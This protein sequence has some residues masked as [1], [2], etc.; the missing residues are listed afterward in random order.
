M[1][2]RSSL[3][4][5]AGKL[6]GV[7]K[8]RDLSLRGATQSTRFIPGVFTASGGNK[9]DALAPGN[10]YKYHTFST[11]GNFVVTG[12]AGDIECL[13]VGGGGA[14][15]FCSGGGGGGGIAYIA[16]IPVPTGTYAVTVGSG[17]TNSNNSPRAPQ[18]NGGDS[19]IVLPVG[20]VTGYGG[21]STGDY[22][23][24]NSYPMPSTGGDGGSGAGGGAVAP[25]YAPDAPYPA[26]WYNPS[27]ATQPGKPTFGGVVTNYGVAGGRGGPNSGSPPDP[28]HLSGGGGGGAG[29]QGQD[30]GPNGPTYAGNGGVGQPFPS[31]AY[32]LCFPGSDTPNLTPHSPDNTHY[33]GG[34]G[35][36]LHRAGGGGTGAP[37]TAG[38]TGGYGGGGQGDNGPSNPG[39]C[40]GQDMLGGGSAGAGG[41]TST[42]SI[43]GGDGVV[44]IRYQV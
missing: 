31:F 20:T 14:A 8:E 44:I 36:G 42:S 34:G 23:P 29:G 37:N 12:A 4:R 18:P 26:P 32:P 43:T 6:L 39:T 9:S 15:D 40:N 3:A 24:G 19:S 38:G 5:S 25:Q 27:G 35:G 17:A 22:N 16:T 10:G 13:I 7:F 41:K 28:R 21:G 1:P 33:G 30:A 11:N 2:F